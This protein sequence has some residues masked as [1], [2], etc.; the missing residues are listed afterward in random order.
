MFDFLLLPSFLPFTTALAVVLGLTALELVMLFIG[1]SLMG[2]DAEAG[3]DVDGPDI[4]DISDLDL[5]DLAS[6]DAADIEMMDLDAAGNGGSAAA[7]GPAAWLGLG[8]VPFLIWLAVFLMAFGLIGTGVQFGLDRFCG[9]TA[10]LGL[11]LPTVGATAL[12]CARGFGAAFARLLPQTESE[13]LSERSLGRRRGV[14]TQGT[15]SEGRPA[16]VRVIDGFGN[17]H[18]LRAVPL[19]RGTSLAQGTEVLVM[20]DRRQNRYVLIPVS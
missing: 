9:L 15:A 19:E 11:A 16:E 12:F 4:A 17:S 8:K 20:R 10:P 3:L 14:I 2:G 5:G 7:V 13:A 1:G 18:H 6:V